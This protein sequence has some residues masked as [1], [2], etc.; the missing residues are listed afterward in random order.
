MLTLDTAPRA[1]RLPDGLEFVIPGPA[2][3]KKAMGGVPGSAHRYLPPDSRD[4]MKLVRDLACRVAPPEPWTGAMDVTIEVYVAPGKRPYTFIP[5][6]AATASPVTHYP[7][8]KPDLANILKGIEDALNGLVWVDDSQNVNV[9]LTKRFGERDETV[10]TVR[11]LEAEPTQ[12]ALLDP[13]PRR[14]RRKSAKLVR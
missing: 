6:T 8:S 1:V 10:V 9:T 11:R 5:P 2:V 14:R 12:V 4:W 13:V 3:G 7:T